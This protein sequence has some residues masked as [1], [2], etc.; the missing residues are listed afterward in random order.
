M[1]GK[2]WDIRNLTN[3]EKVKLILSVVP[4]G[5][6]NRWVYTEYHVRDWL[7]LFYNEEQGITN[8]TYYDQPVFDGSPFTE[9]RVY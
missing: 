3:A 2:K 6:G 7:Y 1:L 5:E 4:E 9:L 8:G